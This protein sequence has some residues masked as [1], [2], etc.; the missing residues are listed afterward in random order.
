MN[1]NVIQTVSE[2]Y[3]IEGKDGYTAWAETIDNGN[4]KE[5]FAALSEFLTLCIN[6]G[7]RLENKHRKEVGIKLA[8]P[9]KSDELNL[10]LSAMLSMTTNIVSDSAKTGKN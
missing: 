3:E 4:S 1:I 6:E 7:I 10:S 5:K 2:K 9:I 8:E